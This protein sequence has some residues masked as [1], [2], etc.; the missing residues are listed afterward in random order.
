MEMLSGGFTW[1]LRVSLEKKKKA[2]MKRKKVFNT[3]YTLNK[4]VVVQD[5]R[6]R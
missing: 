3:A 4:N 1:K 2:H 6:E 5:L